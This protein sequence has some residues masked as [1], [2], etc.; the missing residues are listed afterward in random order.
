MRPSKWLLIDKGFR[1]NN[2]FGVVVSPL[3]KENLSNDYRLS[4]GF[5]NIK[6]TKFELPSPNDSQDAQAASCA[7]CDRVLY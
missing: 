7:V 5:L 6:K 3:E 4:D 1:E 2:S